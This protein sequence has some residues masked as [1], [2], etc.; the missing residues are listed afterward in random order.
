MAH[1]GRNVLQ[2]SLEKAHCAKRSLLFWEIWV[3]GEGK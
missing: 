3:Y 2:T 1:N